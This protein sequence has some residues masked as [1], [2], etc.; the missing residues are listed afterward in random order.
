MEEMRNIVNRFAVGGTIASIAPLGEGLI[1]DTY[2]VRTAETDQPDYVLQRINHHVFP[3]VD[4]VM[5]NIAAVTGHIRHKLEAQGTDDLDRRVLT[6]IH[7]KDDAQQLYTQVDGNYWRLM[8]FIPR[9]VTKQVV[10]P[11]SSRAAG[12]AFGQFQAMLA[13]IAVPLGETIKDFHN[14]EFRLQQLREVVKNDPA[15]RVAEPQVQAMLREIESRAVEMCKAERMGREGILPKRVCHCDTKVNNM[16]FDAQDTD[17]VLCVI[18]LDTVMP[19]FIFS[20]Y[21]DFLRTA[22]NEV[23]EDC[24]EMERVAFRT[25]IFEA[26]TEGYLR[27]AGSFLLPV[28][29]ENLPYAVALFPYMQCVRFL[30]DYLS[31]DHYWKCQYPTHNFVRA[32]NQF[33]LLLS[34]EQ[35]QPQMEEFIKKLS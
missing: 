10:N 8:I 18:D 3:D 13:D 31:G 17:R 11:E 32:N 19:N 34:I 4:M 21:G 14:M 15:G 1:N 28:E 5:R 25:D 9:T 27:S 22:A 20:D 12:E 2:L 24:P 30:W 16:L 26:F 29:V 35:H 23:A 6:F 7:L 33:H